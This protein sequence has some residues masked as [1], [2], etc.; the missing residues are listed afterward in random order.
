M[1]AII[2]CLSLFLAIVLFIV[3][4]GDKSSEPGPNLVPRLL[5]V[6]DVSN[7]EINQTFSISIELE[8]ISE[9]IFAISMQISFA[10][11]VVSY[12]DSIGFE[13]EAFFG[14]D[15]IYFTQE[16][17]SNLHLSITRLQ[18]QNEVSGS[19][20][21]C[22]LYFMA[23]NSGDCAFEIAEEHLHFYDDEGI[24]IDMSELEIGSALIHID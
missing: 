7:V 5:I 4:C 21:I 16:E 8:N 19:G 3:G 17:N 6:A 13:N 12:T 11:S 2:V 18:G 23:E 14:Q 20:T 24:I 22:K 15:V 1:K 10:N 9:P